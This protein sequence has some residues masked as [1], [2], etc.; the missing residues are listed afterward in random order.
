MAMSVAQ[1]AKALGISVSLIRHYEKE[2]DLQFGRTKGGQR[3]ITDRDLENL[4]IIRSFRDRNFPIE[5]IRK[6]LTPPQGEVSEAEPDLKDVIGALIARQDELERAVKVQQDAIAQLLGENQQLKLLQDRVQLLLEAPKE[7]DP[8]VAALAEQVAALEA[9][10]E[11]EAAA[12][13][14]KL[15]ALQDAVDAQP[16]AV[17]SE[18]LENLQSKL[19]DLEREIQSH[20]APSEDQQAISDL[21]KK[22]QDIESALAAKAR[23]PSDE[24]LKG[25]QRRLLELEAAFATREDSGPSQ[26]EGL[27]DTLVAAI[28]EDAKRRK[29]WWQFWG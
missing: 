2:F 25:L 16:D 29:P 20:E 11:E 7:P 15:Q 21:Q 4:R 27:L 12:L 26:E 6:Q 5:E 8:Q 13:R 19:A 24:A 22:L 1:A 9:A 14:E 18:D 10:R 3:I 17:A 23:G 28:Q